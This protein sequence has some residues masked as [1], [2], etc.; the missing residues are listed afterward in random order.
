MYNFLLTLLIVWA[1]ET[2][3]LLFFGVITGL[4]N[5]E[6]LLKFAKI[7]YYDVFLS[8]LVFIISNEDKKEKQEVRF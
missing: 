6:G 4:I 8:I 7:V 2:S 5:K 1:K 3:K